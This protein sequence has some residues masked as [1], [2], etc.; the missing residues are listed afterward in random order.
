MRPDQGQIFDYSLTEQPKIIYPNTTYDSFLGLFK[1]VATIKK[2]TNQKKEIKRPLRER[3]CVGF[4]RVG[5][6]KNGAYRRTGSESQSIHHPPSTIHH[7]SQPATLSGLVAPPKSV[8]RQRDYD[9]SIPRNKC[10][11]QLSH[12]LAAFVG[13]ESS[14]PLLRY[15]HLHEESDLLSG[16]VARL[17]PPPPSPP[18]PPPPPPPPPSSLR[19]IVCT[20]CHRKIVQTS[21]G[22]GIPTV[23]DSSML[24]D[25]SQVRSWCILAFYETFDHLC[26]FKDIPT[27]S[28]STREGIR[29]DVGMIFARTEDLSKD[30]KFKL[31]SIF[32]LVRGFSK[33]PSGSSVGRNEEQ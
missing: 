11:M 27:R 31:Y 18:S 30:A 7:H 3:L 2:E 8:P 32:G 4:K 6:G 5:D 22:D 23:E 20:A 13:F 26:S 15:Q 21:R 12:C 1:R 25:T 33:E 29:M 19:Y 17:P 24:Y 14:G 28:R 10:R 9:L 16:L